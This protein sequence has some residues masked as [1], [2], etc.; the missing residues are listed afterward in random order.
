MKRALGIALSCLLAGCGGGSGV[1]G[2][3]DSGGT[4][5]QPLPTNT[6]TFSGTV[7]DAVTNLP[8]ANATVVF[9]GNKRVTGNDGVFS[10]QNV[11]VPVTTA[12]SIAL[13][14]SLSQFDTR[15]LELPLG[16]GQIAPQDIAL[17]PHPGTASVT[18][19]VRDA[20]SQNNLPNAS[21][22]VGTGQAAREARTDETG[23]FLITGLEAGRQQLL[24]NATGFV[25]SQ[26]IL[27][28]LPIG[29]TF[30]LS[31]PIDLLPAGT[32]I[33]VTGT[34][35]DEDGNALSGATVR[36]GNLSASSQPNGFYQLTGVPVGLQTFT[37]S[38]AG[39]L[40]STFQLQVTGSLGQVN[41]VLFRSGVNPPV[42][43]FTVRG[44]VTL[45]GTTD[46]G[47][48]TITALEQPGDVQRD[49]VTTASD[50]RYQLFIPEGTYKLRATRAG[51]A[52][53]EQNVTVP[54]G[55]QTVDNVNFTLTPQ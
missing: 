53:S 22:V 29:V 14:A 20:Q 40:T 17:T 43:P 28:S 55:G 33:T 36:V 42:S 50:G 15:L 27:D 4:N 38:G 11:V 30:S 47:G 9:G 10:Y 54:P 26:L 44:R 23:T 19:R 7:R 48:V 51:F 49:S 41:V 25:T 18:G 2:L 8:L 3:P 32:T 21:V 6:A 31:A 1:F 46:F 45:G 16:T 12:Q 37:F 39:F 52:T 13:S 35:R 24:A 34:V 5:Q